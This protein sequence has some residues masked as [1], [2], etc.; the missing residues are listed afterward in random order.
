MSNDDQPTPL[1]EW[2][3]KHMEKENEKRNIF[4]NISSHSSKEWMIFEYET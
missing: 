4:N 1:M 2:K 3:K